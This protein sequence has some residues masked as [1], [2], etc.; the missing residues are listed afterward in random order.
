[1]E[2]ARSYQCPGP[3]WPHAALMTI[4][5]SL[6]GYVHIFL[7]FVFPFAFIPGKQRIEVLRMHCED[8]MGRGNCNSFWGDVASRLQ[9][10]ENFHDIWALEGL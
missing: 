7:V 10:P 3:K 2:A 4:E 1:M 8:Q 9:K 5:S 6:N